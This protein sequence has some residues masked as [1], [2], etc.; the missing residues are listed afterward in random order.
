RWMN[1]ATLA[2]EINQ[3][4][5]GVLTNAGTCRRLLDTPLPE[6]D[7]AREVAKR[8]LRD[9]HR[10]SEVVSRL[11][12]LFSKRECALEALDLNEPVREAIALSSTALQR[13]AIVLRSDLANNLPDVTA[14]RVQLQQVILNLLR[15]A[16]DAMID[17][18]GRPRRLV[19]KPNWR[20]VAVPA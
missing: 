3:P 8:T 10:A 4:L 11:R 20:T 6:I 15:N 16:S 5:Q 19:V 18:S 9:A 14:D 12:A 2:H 7:T 17:V 1:R 13:T